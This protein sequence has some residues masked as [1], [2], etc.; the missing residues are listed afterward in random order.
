MLAIVLHFHT[1]MTDGVEA[2]EAEHPKGGLSKVD[3]SAQ[4]SKLLTTK[5]YTER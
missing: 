1:Q 4:R 2:L 3:F 5:V